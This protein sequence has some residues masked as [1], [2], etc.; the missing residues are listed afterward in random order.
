LLR[1]T[2]LSVEESLKV[3]VASQEEQAWEASSLKAEYIQLLSLRALSQPD[4][5]LNDTI[6]WKLVSLAL[7][8]CYHYFGSTALAN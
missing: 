2:H 1:I 8:I 5:E 4:H 6:R 7:D 3:A